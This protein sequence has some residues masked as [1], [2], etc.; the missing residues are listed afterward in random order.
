MSTLIDEKYNEISRLRTA[1]DRNF[2]LWSDIIDYI[3]NTQGA[4]EAKM[5]VNNAIRNDLYKK[6]IL[7][8]IDDNE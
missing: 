1:N 3:I 2:C 4:H 8:Y 6:H 7:K 5:I